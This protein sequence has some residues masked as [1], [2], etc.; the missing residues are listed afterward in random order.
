MTSPDQHII[1][2][3]QSG[4]QPDTPP[5]QEGNR[6][7]II[8]LGLIGGSI[9]LRLSGE[10]AVAGYDVN[11]DTINM[12]TSMGIATLQSIDD[13][14]AYADIIIICTPIGSFP[15]IVQLLA[16]A[17]QRQSAQ[18]QSNPPIV[19]DTCSVKRYIHEWA[20][21][22]RNVGIP[23]VGTHP[24]AGK[25]TNGI[26]SAQA[27]LF[28]K[29]S[30][31]VSITDSVD[32]AALLRVSELILST[33]SVLVPVDPATH[34]RSVALVSHLPHVIAAMMSLLLQSDELSTMDRSLVAGSFDDITRV[35]GSPPELTSQ[36]CTA[37]IDML[38]ESFRQFSTEIEKIGY[39]LTDPEHAPTL[40]SNL[41]TEAH[42]AY[43]QLHESNPEP[44]GP[45]PYGTGNYNTGIPDSTSIHSALFT[46]D[47]PQTFINW[48]LGLGHDGGRIVEIGCP[49]PTEVSISF[50]LPP[51]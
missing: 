26:M 2:E 51:R 8:G 13:I 19:A 32:L 18:L 3:Q 49:S 28:D 36:M 9:A 31:A 34:D 5:S 10:M 24:M 29:H 48:M 6:I 38:A 16:S 35:A 45:E 47:D 14:I 12:A 30:W 7:G 17:W 46:L 23:F 50:S 44:Y 41:F 42:Q 40:L 22:L 20:E 15:E 43:S 4:E 21:Q 1:Y 25:H 27:D 37:N 33:G 39:E 11:P